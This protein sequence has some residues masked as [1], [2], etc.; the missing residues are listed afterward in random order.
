LTIVEC[1]QI[2]CEDY[3][4]IEGDTDALWKMCIA[5]GLRLS[6]NYCKVED[7]EKDAEFRFAWTPLVDQIASAV[8]RVHTPT[9]SPHL[10]WRVLCVRTDAGTAYER[11]AGAQWA[12]SSHSLAHTRTSDSKYQT[13]PLLSATVRS[14][15]EQDVGDRRTGLAAALTQANQKS[16]RLPQ[17]PPSL[18]PTSQAKRDPENDRNILD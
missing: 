3:K 6:R 17:A 5:V 18:T 4:E 15:S 9:P 10:I 8:P 13:P 2:L 14:R 11:V 12:A 7:R 1:E 16:L